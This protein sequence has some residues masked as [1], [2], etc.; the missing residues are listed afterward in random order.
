ML[1]LG[2]HVA[3]SSGFGARGARPRPDA[4]GVADPSLGWAIRRRWRRFP[5]RNKTVKRH[6]HQLSQVVRIQ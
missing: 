1:V 2:G 6:L 4:T 3:E 5:A